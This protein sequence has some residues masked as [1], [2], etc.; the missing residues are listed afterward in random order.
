MAAA[1]Q[2]LT[3]GILTA[4]LS[5]WLTA[6]GCKQDL[7]REWL[8]SKGVQSDSPLA[9]MGFH[10]VPSMVQLHMH[11]MYQ[12]EAT[13]GL[14]TK[15][16]WLSFTSGFLIPVSLASSQLQEHGCLQLLGEDLLKGSLFCHRC[17]Q[18]CNNMPTLIRH[19]GSCKV[20]PLG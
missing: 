10:S 12:D 16:H 19:I 6:C 20:T 5:Q 17:S 8:E 3:A 14:K 9:V 15:K 7:G 2:C 18:A 13:A 11:V 1:V 4:R